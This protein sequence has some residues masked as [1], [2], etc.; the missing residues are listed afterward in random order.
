MNLHE[1]DTPFSVIDHTRL[2]ANLARHQA[3]TLSQG[4]NARPHAKTH[5]IPQ[6]AALQLD[7]GA[8]GVTLATIG[9]AE[10][11]VDHGITDIFLAYPL[12]LTPSKAERLNR[13]SRKAL[14]A[15]GVDS[16]ESIRQAAS[17]LGQTSIEFLIEVDS[18]HHRSGLQPEQCVPLAAELQKNGLR[19][20]GVFTYPGHS[21]HPEHKEQ[22]SSD[23]E[24]ALRIATELLLDAGFEVPVRSG[25]STPSVESTSGYLTETRSGVYALGDAQQ[26]ELG[27]STYDS[28]AMTVI[29][30][31]VSRRGSTAVVD[32]GSKVLGADRAAW[33]TGYGRVLSSP[34]ARIVALSEHHATIEFPDQAPGLGELIRVIPNHV[35]NAMNLVDEVALVEDEQ[36]IE[37][38]SVAARGRNS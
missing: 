34:E 26:I 18:G 8:V 14:I 6:L 11:F 24:A 9:E 15:M 10:V 38:W 37:W 36:V 16:L 33:A 5:K 35:C 30:T 21:Y 1:I 12:W 28:V 13:L 2:L 3:R 22:A 25:G 4:L 17:V 23:E 20:T 31:V 27:T 32:A 19:F 7:Y 29:A